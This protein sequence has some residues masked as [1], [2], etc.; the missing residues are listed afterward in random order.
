MRQHRWNGSRSSF[1]PVNAPAP[2]HTLFSLIYASSAAELFSTADLVLLLETCRRNNTAAGITGMLLYKAGNFLQVLEGEEEAVRRLHAKIHHDPR[3]RGL[4]T[5][6]EH[7]IPE[8]QF[9]EWSMGFR[10]LS[11][12]ALRELPGYNE[13][14]NVPLDDKSFVAQPSRARRLLA[15]FRQ[16]M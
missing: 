9:G 8:R 2:V 6:T 7:M 11:D 3:H 10:N 5:L 16:K 12:P 4:I 15:T 1:T 14:L 13:F